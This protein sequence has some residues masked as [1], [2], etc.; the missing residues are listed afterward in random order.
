M[1]FKQLG[2]FSERVAVAVCAIS[3]LLLASTLVLKPSAAGGT[4][5]TVGVTGAL[6]VLCILHAIATK[7]WRRALGFT[8][9]SFAISWAL[10]FI[11]CNYALWFG[12]YHYTHVL[13]LSIGHVPVVVVC[14]WEALIYPS[15]LIVD[16]MIGSLT[17]RSR[18]ARLLQ[19]GIASLATGLVATAWDMMNDPLAVHLHMW[20]WTFGGAYMH[21]LSGGVPYSNMW[22]W[23]GAVFIIGLLYKLLIAGR[24]GGPS[25]VQTGSPLLFGA[26]IYTTWFC[27]AAYALLGY[28]LD[29]PLFI[30]VF[31]M[32][33]TI[34]FCWGKYF[35]A[36][37]Q[38]SEAP[39]PVTTSPVRLDEAPSARHGPTLT[40]VKATGPS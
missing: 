16:S 40:G 20:R 1:S 3:V 6:L 22:G 8:A 18:S 36:R 31:T 26:A 32:M 25:V 38:A 11:G 24:A 4:L 21:Q 13:G 39:L 30:G 23:V 33:P 5:G 37:T 9:L 10:E 27:L 19:I 29:E 12:N 34:A 35:L 17:A 2:R 7:G 14:A 15:L 28:H